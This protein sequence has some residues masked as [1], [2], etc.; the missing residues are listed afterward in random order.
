RSW[1]V[2]ITSQAATS[3]SR[4]LG[5][6]REPSMA[7]AAATMMLSTFAM[8]PAP[9]SSRSSAKLA[10]RKAWSSGT[11]PSTALQR[12]IGDRARFVACTLF[13]GVSRSTQG[14]RRHARCDAN[15]ERPETGPWSKL[16]R[17]QPLDS[18]AVSAVL[19]LYLRQCCP[20]P[21][22][23]R[24]AAKSTE[25]RRDPSSSSG[26]S[27]SLPT[28]RSAS[29]KCT[30]SASDSSK[31]SSTWMAPEGHEVRPRP[32]LVGLRGD[33]LV[34]LVA[35]EGQRGPE[36]PAHEPLVVVGGGVDQVPE[37]LLAGPLAGRD[38]LRG[39]RVG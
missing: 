30:S 3:R 9:T 11:R 29:R 34:L 2:T 8:R 13:P 5:A 6:S 17:P 38:R 22:R 16:P 19:S 20:I 4:S 27:S 35:G 36:L 25:A 39:A 14:R 33:P 24:L 10:A 7:S 1:A 28:A 32:L 12:A 31:R 23:T 26:S 18:R 21:Q 15:A 37:H